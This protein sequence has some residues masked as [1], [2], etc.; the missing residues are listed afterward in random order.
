MLNHSPRVLNTKPVK[1]QVK[2]RGAMFD[3]P[4]ADFLTFWKQ[5]VIS[6]ADAAKHANV[7]TRLE[8]Q[9]KHLGEETPNVHL[10]LRNGSRRLMNEELPSALQSF[11]LRRVKRKSTDGKS[12]DQLVSGRNR[13]KR[14][15]TGDWFID[16]F[17]PILNSLQPWMAGFTRP[18]LCVLYVVDEYTESSGSLRGD[19][20][21]IGYILHFA[22]T[23]PAGA[24][25]INTN[26]QTLHEVGRMTTEATLESTIAAL[27]TPVNESQPSTM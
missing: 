4:M 13:G 6:M 26:N 25:T 21:W 10:V 5:Q 2:T 19:A 16:G 1:G 27:P 15:Y 11:S 23:G 14:I 3:L 18:V 12:I 8:A 7:I 9:M 20:P 22:H 17:T 24:V